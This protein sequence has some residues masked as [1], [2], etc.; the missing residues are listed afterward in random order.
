MGPTAW[1][2]T[3]HGAFPKQRKPLCREAQR[4]LCKHRSSGYSERVSVE[5]GSLANSGHPC[6][7]CANESKCHLGQKTNL[8]FSLPNTKS[9]SFCGCSLLLSKKL[10]TRHTIMPLSGHGDHMEKAC[11]SLKFIMRGVR[12]VGDQDARG[13]RTDDT[14]SVSDMKESP[15]KQTPLILSGLPLF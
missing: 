4:Y 12:E 6:T 10:R 14:L 1:V 7:P 2:R 15:W 9:I 3:A 5:K 11:V 13:L 8:F